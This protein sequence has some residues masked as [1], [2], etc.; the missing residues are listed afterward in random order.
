MDTADLKKIWLEKYKIVPEQLNKLKEIESAETA[1]NA[2]I[3]AVIK[4]SGENLKKLI[5]DEELT[6]SELEDIKQ[7]KILTQKDVVKGIFKCFKNGIAEEWIT[8]EKEVYDWLN[9][10]I[11]YDRLQMGGQG[12][13]VANALATV[14][15]KKVVVHTN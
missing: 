3:D 14:G 9:K 13:I 2:N 11:G 6:L 1:F 7:T 15:I 4:M 8:E 5:Q 10:K 12:G